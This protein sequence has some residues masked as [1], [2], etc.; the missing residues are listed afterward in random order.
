MLYD[1]S[2]HD[3]VELNTEGELRSVGDVDVW[4]ADSQEF[5][6]VFLREVD[7]PRVRHLLQE[8]PV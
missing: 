4:Y 3:G 1:L 8:S 2:G 6:Y 7:S 5:S